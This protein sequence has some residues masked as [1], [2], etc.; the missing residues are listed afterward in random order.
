MTIVESA[1]AR[2]IPSLS[3]LLQKPL[4]LVDGQSPEASGTFA[5]RFTAPRVCVVSADGRPFT[6]PER[7]LLGT[8]FDM[9]RLADETEMKFTELERDVIRW[10]VRTSDDGTTRVVGQELALLL[11]C[12]PTDGE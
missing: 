10:I 9:I 3:A 6:E 12:R 4:C 5:I 7:Q 1:A 2:M 11:L 8:L